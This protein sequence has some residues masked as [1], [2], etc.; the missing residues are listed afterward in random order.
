M[1]KCGRKEILAAGID[2][3]KRVVKGFSNQSLFFLYL[4]LYD[5]WPF[6]RTIKSYFIERK[7]HMSEYVLRTRE[8]SKGVDKRDA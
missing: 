1:T 4:S 2:M 5:S 6:H 3:G 7:V 8:I